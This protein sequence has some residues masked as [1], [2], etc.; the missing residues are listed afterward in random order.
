MPAAPAR[1]SAA[2]RSTRPGPCARTAGAPRPAN[3]RAHK[4]KPP[5]RPRTA[6]PETSALIPSSRRWM[7]LAAHGESAPP[8]PRTAAQYTKRR[9]HPRSQAKQR[10]RQPNRGA[11]PP[12]GD[13]QE[14]AP[15]RRLTAGLPVII[16]SGFCPSSLARSSVLR[17]P[18]ARSSV[19]ASSRRAHS[20]VWR[21]ECSASCGSANSM[22]AGR[23]RISRARA[24]AAVMS[25]QTFS[26]PSRSMKP[27]LVI[28]SSGCV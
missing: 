6:R 11:C 15:L 24:K 28:T 7:S 19:S 3:T 8:F 12:G 10:E 17:I 9:H 14:H 23:P 27:E 25:G 2:S 20:T 16:F 18:W 4:P 21:S 13:A 26:L 22:T 1:G 5:R